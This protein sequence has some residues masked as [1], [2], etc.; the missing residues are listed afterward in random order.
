MPKINKEDWDQICPKCKEEVYSDD[1]LF[2]DG[3][4]GYFTVK[5]R[6]A[7]CGCTIYMDHTI[8]ID[9]IVYDE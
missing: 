3:D 1:I 2:E 4:Y 5:Y 8:K 7:N 9:Q 6:C